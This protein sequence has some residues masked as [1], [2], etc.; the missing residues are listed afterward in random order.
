[1]IL[2]L[3]YLCPPLAVMMMGRPFAAALNFCLTMFLFW[4]PGVK[5]ALVVYADWLTEKRHNAMVQTINYPGWFT[6]LVESGRQQSQAQPQLPSE[7]ADVGANG[8]VF[9]RR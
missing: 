5:H 1:M 2:L 7:R 3:C 9:R 4:V 6:A 8:T